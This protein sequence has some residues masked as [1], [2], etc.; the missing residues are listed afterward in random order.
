MTEPVVTPASSP[1]IW[2]SLLH[3]SYNMWSDRDAP[4]WKLDHVS[5]RPYL[6]FDESL[7]ND[8]LPKMAEAGM[9]MVVIDLGDGVRYQSHPEIAVEGA[10]SPAKLREELAKIRQLGLEPI[11]KLNFSTCHDAWLGPYSRCV[12][13]DTY[14]DVCRDLIAEVIDLF[15]QPRFFHLGMD[16]E[17]AEHQRYYG[18]VV[19]RQYD[20]WWHDLAFYAAQ[21]EKGGVRPWVWSDYVWHHPEAFYANM[22]LSILQSN[23]YYGTEFGPDVVRTRTYPELEQYGYDQIPTFSNWSD[24]RNVL[25]TVQY[26]REHIASPRLKGFLQTIWKPT[27]EVC[28]ERHEQAIDL[29]RQARAW[30]LNPRV[31]AV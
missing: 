31:G 9:N 14:Y 23:W 6:R 30:W 24:P 18:Y 13:T 29:V 5:A 11:P 4:E 8:L 12:S 1:M 28:R 21:V 25:M 16:E 7:W 27:L 10:W 2:G 15:D 26:C 19:I 20:L 3:L 17:T 22:P